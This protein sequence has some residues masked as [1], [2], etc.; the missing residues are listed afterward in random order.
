MERGRLR[1]AS[2]LKNSGKEQR[3]FGQSAI[4]TATKKKKT[5]GEKGKSNVPPIV[6]KGGK[7]PRK[8]GR[9]QEELL[10]KRRES[11]GTCL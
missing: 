9:W 8:K 5:G 6:K 7:H 11:T 2:S 1:R 10:R 4:S 3:K